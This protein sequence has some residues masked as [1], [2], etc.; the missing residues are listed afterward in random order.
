MQALQPFL[1]CVPG[2][3]A[4]DRLASRTLACN[5]DLR[6]RQTQPICSTRH[7][8]PHNSPAPLVVIGLAKNTHWHRQCAVTW[9]I[10]AGIA[11]SP[12]TSDAVPAPA[13]DLH[14]ESHDDQHGNGTAGSSYWVRYYA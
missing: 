2:A 7:A 1:S 5:A 4:F 6:H 10:E 11:G 12:P 8:I 13:V 9:S 14:S 3:T